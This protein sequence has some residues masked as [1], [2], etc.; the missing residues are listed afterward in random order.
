YIDG[1]FLSLTCFK[2]KRGEYN[3]AETF[4]RLL[5]VPHSQMRVRRLCPTSNLTSTFLLLQYWRQV[6]LVTV[7]AMILAVFFAQIHPHYLSKQWKQMRS[8]IFCSVAGYG[9]VPT[10]HWICITGGFSSEL[11]QAFVPRVLGMYFI[12]ALALIFYVSKV[13]ERYFPG[14]LNYLGSSHQVWHLLLVLMFYWW[15][16]TSGFL[17]AYRHS[18]PCPEGS[19]ICS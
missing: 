4:S 18:Q 10:V 2:L 13:P 15:H 17:M 7:L 6:Y 8:L 19:F 5:F 11:V 14:Q 16:Q 9:L 12:A 1:Y 3:F